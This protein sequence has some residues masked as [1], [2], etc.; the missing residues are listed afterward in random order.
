M[1]GFFILALVV[2]VAVAMFLGVDREMQSDAMYFRELAENLANGDGYVLQKNTFWSGRL[3]M[4]RLPGWPF[5]ASVPIRMFSGVQSDRIV[6]ITNIIIN[7]LVVAML[8]QLTWSVTRAMGISLIAGLIYL[9]H[10]TA[11]HS[12]YTGLSEPLFLLLVGL[13]FFLVLNERVGVQI[14][15]CILLG[16]ACLVRANF[17]LMPFA[18]GAVALLYCL[19]KKAFD[20]GVFLQF[21]LGCMLFLLPPMFWAARNYRICGSF[22]V[23]STIGGQTFYGGNN[24]ITAGW[25]QHWGHWV[26][27]NKVPG[28]IPMRKLSETM[29]EYEV[30]QYYYA[31]GK[32]FLR[33]HPGKVPGLLLGKLVRAYIPV[34]WKLSIGG[35]WLAIYRW[36]LYILV[37]LGIYSGWSKI[38][39]TYRFVLLGMMLTNVV[40][41][42]IFWGS[43]RFAFALEPFLLPFA[44]YG[45]MW[46]HRKIYHGGT[47]D[48]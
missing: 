21:C 46:F 7:A 10:P 8:V 20:R 1:A 18:C 33:E 15:G 9:F 45:F 12:F 31:R 22:P 24:E 5:V 2:N 29:T 48:L 11:I 40:T 41:V 47:E 27:P 32:S 43:P 35:L 36:M 16:S 34:P 19:F 17:V 6:R 44:G 37:A 30:D 13:G 4:R 38:N 3:T 25:N 14:C 28:D 23:L 26:F 39:T 42:L